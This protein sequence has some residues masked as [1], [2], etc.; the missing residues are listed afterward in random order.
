VQETLD[1]LARRDEPL[2]LKLERQPGQKEARYA[3]LL[4]GKVEQHSVTQQTEMDHFSNSQMDD[5]SAE[6]KR[7][8]NEL[9]TFRAEFEEFKKQFD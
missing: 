5:L 2:V 9:A 3:H 8:A 4:S 7:L 1:D 6:I